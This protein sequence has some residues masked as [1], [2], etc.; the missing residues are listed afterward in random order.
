MNALYVACEAIWPPWA[1]KRALYGPF[2]AFVFLERRSGRRLQRETKDQNVT[3]ALVAPIPDHRTRSDLY[4][5][6]N[7]EVVSDGV[8][9][10]D[11]RRVPSREEPVSA[12]LMFWDK[13][14]IR[15][16]DHCRLP[17]KPLEWIKH[18]KS[19]WCT[20]YKSSPFRLIVARSYPSASR[21]MTAVVESQ[22]VFVSAGD[23]TGC[24]KTLTF[25]SLSS[26]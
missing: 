16:I 26:F 23:L 9:F 4:T 20:S 19:V 21:P 1:T 18:W 17:S 8:P 14:R 13:G 24:T 7:S 25:Q 3:A 15:R 2:K 12:S 11:R 10:R 22:S 6:A 5:S